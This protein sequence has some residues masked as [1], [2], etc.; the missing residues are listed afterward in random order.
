[1]DTL[2]Q[3]SC[4]EGIATLVM[5]DGKA[6]V[7]SV[8]MLGALNAALDKAEQEARVVVLQGRPGMF[9]GGFDLAA[10]KR[11]G[12]EVLEMLEGGARLSERLLGYPLPVIAACTGHAIAMGVFLLLSADLRI[13]LAE[14]ARFQANEVRIGMIVPYFAL[15]VCRQRLAPNQLHS[16]TVLGM[17]F[18]SAQALAA[19]FLDEIVAAEALTAT[20]QRHAA[21]LLTLNGEAFVATKRRLRAGALAA[22][23]EAVLADGVAW[24]AMGI[25]H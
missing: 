5:D 25:G 24:R 6:N 20:V 15:E 11:G 7:M 8:A 21:D 10:F 16:A 4:E 1:M 23:A 12:P 19:G 22:M 17:P 14:G 18:F 3:Y 13:G 2:L 9:S